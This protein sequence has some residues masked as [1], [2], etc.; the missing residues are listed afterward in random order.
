MIRSPRVVDALIEA[1]AD[2]DKYVRE[3]AARALGGIGDAQAVPGL[4]GLPNEEGL[5]GL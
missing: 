5:Q 4:A 3:N 1:L 2:E